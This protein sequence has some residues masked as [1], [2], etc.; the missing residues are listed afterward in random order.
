MVN[1][2]GMGPFQE[3][4]LWSAVQSQQTLRVRLK[5][6]LLLKLNVSYNTGLHAYSS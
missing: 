2:Q 1:L 5:Y 4:T 6:N 3:T